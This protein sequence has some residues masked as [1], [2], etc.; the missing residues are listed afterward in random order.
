MRKNISRKKEVVIF[1]QNKVIFFLFYSEIQFLIVCW[2]TL[3]YPQF[4]TSKPLYVLKNNLSTENL[5]WLIRDNAVVRMKKKVEQKTN[6]LRKEVVIFNGK[7]DYLRIKSYF[8]MGMVFQE[9]CQNSEKVIYWK[10][11]K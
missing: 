7:T 6:F 9:Q 11:L 4:S 3:H 1:Q 5:Q 2:K 8:L 10:K